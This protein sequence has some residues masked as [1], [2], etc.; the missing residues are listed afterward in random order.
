MADKPISTA[1]IK[2]SSTFGTKLP[3]H[4]LS[5]S[6]ISRDM[7]KITMSSTAASTESG[8]KKPLDISSLMSPPEPPRLE[9]FSQRR[10]SNP[11]GPTVSDVRRLQPISPITP[12]ISPTTNVDDH[13]VNPASSA[14]TAVQDPILYPSQDVTRSPQQQPLFAQDDSID[15]RRIVDEHVNIRPA[16]MFGDASP[17][18]LE[19]YELVIFFSSQVMKKY[20]ENP[21][22]WL[23]RERDQLL[24][25]RRAGARY[26]KFKPQPKPILPAKVPQVRKETQR[27]KTVKPAKVVKATQPSAAAPRPIRSYP[28]TNPGQSSNRLPSATPD[29]SPRRAVAPNRE[30]KDFDSLPNLCPPLDTLPPRSNSLK[31]DWKGTPIDLSNDPYRHLLHPDEVTLAANLR[32]DCATYLTSKRRMFIRRRECLQMG[33]EFRKTDAQQACKIDVNKASKL[34]TA[35][36]KVGWLGKNYMDKYV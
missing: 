8:F 23:K 2:F 25:D 36:E 16:G 28:T 4:L 1:D 3:T 21:K 29:P 24:A 13:S 17:P 5:T 33:K 6:N 32:L 34:W 30:D 7:E 20:Q 10:E 31:V 27:T 19:D 18:K 12:P 9:S 22:L 11:T 26:N 15:V 14:N 35:F